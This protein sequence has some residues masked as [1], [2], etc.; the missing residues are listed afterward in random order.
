MLPP[1]EAVA[2]TS[3]RDL[4]DH[5]LRAFLPQQRGRTRVSLKKLT[6]LST[7]ARRRPKSFITHEFYLQISLCSATFFLSKNRKL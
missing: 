3:I 2:S 6:G 7:E 5:E 4:R 1:V